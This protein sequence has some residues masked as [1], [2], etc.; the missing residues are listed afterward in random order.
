MSTSY[1]P[2][3]ARVTQALI[4]SFS[5]REIDATA[6]IGGFEINQ[7]LDQVGYH[8]YLVV[9]DSIGLLENFALRG[10]EKL[11]LT[12]LGTDL[13]TVINLKSQIYKIDN[14]S[15]VQPLNRLTYK[16]HFVSRVNYEASKKKVIMP[17][18]DETAGYIA[19]QI[20]RR[21]FS[22]LTPYELHELPYNTQCYSIQDDSKRKFYVEP[23]EGHLKCVVPNLTP[24]EAMHFMAQRSY[25]RES[26][27][28]AFRFFENYDGFYFVTDE[29][30]IQRAIE[31]AEKAKKEN[32]PAKYLIDLIYLTETTLEP[33]Y[34]EVHTR[35]IEYIK[36][37][38]R[39]DTS[40]DILSGGYAN[41]AI[42]IDLVRRNVIEKN[43]Y[44]EDYANYTGM[45][46]NKAK[47]SDDVH[48]PDF[49]EKTFD[50]NNA[51][52][53]LIFRDFSQV[54]DNPSPLRADQYYAE[55]SSNKMFYRHHLNTTA[56]SVG[57]KGRLDIQAG[58]IVRIDMPELSIK[59]DRQ[60][61]QQLSGN[62]L[63]DAVTHNLDENTLRTH[64]RLI[65]FNWSI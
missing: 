40:A 3:H 15:I 61:N 47:I 23:T 32:R 28:S 25:S 12:I 42:E 26:N 56:I 6:M 10:E 54:G 34:A 35:L 59:K 1:N 18:E 29:F 17:F 60:F 64:L 2:S 33:S 13:N 9:I 57:V 20:F 22:E 41:K 4:T 63:V 5:N 62:Y 53:F 31:E 58:K 19:E 27:S 48:T 55:I 21:Y 43:F 46:G 50:E 37:D 24:T 36:N 30:L 65:K 51:K 16:I 39:I 8:G 44:Y 11:D 52:R 14:V 49:I 45:S 7:S 38:K